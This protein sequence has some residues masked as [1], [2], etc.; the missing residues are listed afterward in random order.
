MKYHHLNHE[1]RDQLAVLLNQGRPLREIA[2]KLGRSCSTL[3]LELQRNR[4]KPKWGA[5]VYY[6]HK[7]HLKASDRLQSAH[8]RPRLKSAAVHQQV[9]ELLEC[10]WSPELIA[11]RL[12]RRCPEL[13]TPK[14]RN[15][16]PVDL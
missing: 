1:E 13:P 3:A 11:G 15:D 8:R 5:R 9:A 6:P 14:P 4:H 7:A 10:R 16:L 12:R 2:Q